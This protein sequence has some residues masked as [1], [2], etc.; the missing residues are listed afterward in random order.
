MRTHPTHI[1]LAEEVKKWWDLKFDKKQFTALWTSNK[2]EKSQQDILDVA[3]R[4]W[5]IALHLVKDSTWFRVTK[6]LNYKQ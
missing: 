6:V 2:S 4:E 3:K 1:C 5:R